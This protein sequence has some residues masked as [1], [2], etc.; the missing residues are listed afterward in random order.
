MI[1]GALI[2]SRF[3]HCTLDNFRTTRFNAAAHEACQKLARGETEGVFLLGPV[4]VGKTHLLIGLMKAFV[5]HRVP[6][7]P[8]ED[9]VAVPRIRE[10]IEREGEDDGAG[11]PVG[12]DPLERSHEP[13]IEFWPMLDLVSELRSEIKAGELELSRRCRMCDLLVIDDLGAERATDFVREELDRI[14]DWRYRDRR[15]IAV[16][17]NLEDR[18]IVEKYGWRA[19]SRWTE[20]CERVRME[21]PDYRTERA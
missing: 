2:G 9:L 19:I 5:A 17:T 16:A 14:V 8:E 12:L 7:E 10:L 20:S 13:E 1:R 4:G 21:G 3:E 11:D 18:E 6:E 15:S